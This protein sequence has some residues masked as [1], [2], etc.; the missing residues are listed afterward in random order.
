[1]A[2]QN[3]RN[4]AFVPLYALTRDQIGK[5]EWQWNEWLTLRE[6]ADYVKAPATLG[7]MAARVLKSHGVRDRREWRRDT[8][9]PGTHHMRMRAFLG[10]PGA[11]T[12]GHLSPGKTRCGISAERQ[13]R[14]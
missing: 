14:R 11:T 6:A 10:S 7:S 12:V 5:M 1:M 9:E 8:K 2:D 4:A 3:E 13:S